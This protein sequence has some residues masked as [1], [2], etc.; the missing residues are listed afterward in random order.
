M[1]R[2]KF[3]IKSLPKRY[4]AYKNMHWAV[5]AADA[6]KW[7]KMVAGA[8]LAF[9]SFPDKAL[10]KAKVTLT[11]YS[12]RAPDY[13]GLVQAFKPVLDGLVKC[14]VLEDDNMLVIGRPDYQWKK[15]P[16][17]QGSIEVIVEEVLAS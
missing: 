10:T 8:I 5:K 17:G 12:S 4:N 1:Y 13:D 15:V 2:L 11:R 6:K 3:E 14:R 9:G 7:H 16:S